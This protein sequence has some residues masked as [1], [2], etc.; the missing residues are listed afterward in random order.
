M[1]ILPSVYNSVNISDDFIDLG[2]DNIWV[3]IIAGTGS[4]TS[5]QYTTTSVGP[6]K[7]ISTCNVGT[8][9]TGRALIRSN[10]QPFSFNLGMELAARVSIVIPV[11]SIVTDEYISWNG[12]TDFSSG[13]SATNGAHFRYDRLTD[14]NFWACITKSA[15][16]ETKTVTAIPTV[17]NTFYDMA[18]SVVGGKVIFWIDGVKV[19]EHT[20][21][22]PVAGVGFGWS[23]GALKSAGTTGT[24]PI[25]I[26]WVNLQINTSKNLYL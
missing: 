14:G 15:G 6:R 26:D 5:G 18:I 10:L 1:N 12:F 22:I 9:T 4:S 17:I 25:A 3:R 20:T 24:I 11:L 23:V 2:G 8:T 16:A 7:G 13:S 21:N 19:A